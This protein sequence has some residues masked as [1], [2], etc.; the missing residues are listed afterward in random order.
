MLPLALN[1]R[2]LKT[3]RARVYVALHVLPGILMLP[4]FAFA[5]LLGQW[6]AD[7]LGI[8]LN[9]AAARHPNDLLWFTAF[10]AVLVLLPATGCLLG[11]VANALVSR[12]ILGWSSTQITAVYMRSEVP[13]DWFK[14]SHDRMSERRAILA[15]TQ[16][17][18]EYRTIGAARFV[19]TKG[20]LTYG[21]IMFIV[22]YVVPTL[23]GGVGFD[24]ETVAFQA[25]LCGVTGGIL[26]GLIWWL[27]EWDYRKP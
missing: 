2:L 4:S 6:L 18:E 14:P 22:A 5:F 25:V 7:A 8:P 11:W 17:W 13:Q 16:K 1:S 10:V 20:V 24:L 26:T 15:A 27:S 23:F 9:T 3:F 21:I 12:Y 19:L